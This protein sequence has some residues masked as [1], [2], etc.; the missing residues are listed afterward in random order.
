MYGVLYFPPGIKVPAVLLLL[1]KKYNL[2]VW[3][4]THSTTRLTLKICSIFK[5]ITQESLSTE[6]EAKHTITIFMISASNSFNLQQNDVFMKLFSFS[7]I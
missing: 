3:E 2:Q 5:N 1:K 6:S 4:E 7:Q